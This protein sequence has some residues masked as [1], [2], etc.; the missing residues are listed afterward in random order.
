MFEAS[1]EGR[2]PERCVF[3]VITWICFVGNVSDVVKTGRG[4]FC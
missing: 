3:L 1:S 2:L 4:Q